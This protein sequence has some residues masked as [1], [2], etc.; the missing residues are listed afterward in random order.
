[1]RTMIE[2]AKK[3][4]SMKGMPS[5]KSMS[6]KEMDAMMPS[7]KAMNMTKKGMGTMRNSSGKS[8]GRRMASK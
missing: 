7:T 6:Q 8:T 5:M 1:M 4:S 2:D 3:G